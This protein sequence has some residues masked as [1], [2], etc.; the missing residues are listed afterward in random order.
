MS[1][2]KTETAALVSAVRNVTSADIV[3][4]T[5]DLRAINA[6]AERD[7]QLRIIELLEQIAAK[8]EG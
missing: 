3:F 6:A 1:K 2:K 7:R 5:T 8:L 4:E